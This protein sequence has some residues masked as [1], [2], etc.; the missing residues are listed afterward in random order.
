MDKEKKRKQ[1]EWRLRIAEWRSSGLTQALYCRE[2]GLAL[3]TFG[4]WKRRLVESEE[5]QRFVKMAAPGSL[6]ALRGRRMVLLMPDDLRLVFS[7]RTPVSTVSGILEK[8]CG[9]TGRR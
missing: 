5:R 1:H 4:Y 2:N 6:R 9:S 8:L 3:A 7:E